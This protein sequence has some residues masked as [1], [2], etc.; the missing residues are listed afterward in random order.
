MVCCSLLSSCLLQVCPAC[1]SK[2]GRSQN[3]FIA[4]C[5]K[6]WKAEVRPPPLS[7]RR[8]GQAPH[9]S[10]LGVPRRPC[11]KRLSA[12]SR[13]LLGAS[14]FRGF[15][16]NSNFS[17]PFDPHRW[18]LLNRQLCSIPSSNTRWFSQAGSPRSA[19]IEKNPPEPRRTGPDKP[20][21]KLV[22]CEADRNR[23][24]QAA[25][26]TYDYRGCSC[27]PGAEGHK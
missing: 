10:P 15:R 25:G 26:Q 18:G 12:V 2:E 21:F 27:I 14:S 5:V 9:G 4:E 20:D 11:Q 3:N 6:G 19:Y 1:P 24:R 8:N 22:P 13:R 7:F 16:P 17:G 23:P